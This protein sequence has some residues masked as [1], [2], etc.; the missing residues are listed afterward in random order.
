MSNSE[1]YIPKMG[2]TVLSDS[3]NECIV[4]HVGE[5]SLFVKWSDG[6]EFSAD[7]DY[8]RQIPTKSDV[9]R[10]QL[11]MILSK[12]LRYLDKVAKEIQNAGFTIPKKV[13]RSE[14]ADV[15][16][17]NS[18]MD[19]VEDENLADELCNLLGDLVEDEA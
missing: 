11:I 4:L 16:V 10:E 5:K 7:F 13:K 14:I 19:C 9:E 12:N 17:N 2:D 15:V 6:E 8:F 1:K 18:S 3:G